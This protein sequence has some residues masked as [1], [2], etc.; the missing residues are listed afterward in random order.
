MDVAA[1]SRRHKLCYVNVTNYRT[2]NKLVYF[3]YAAVTYEVTNFFAA[4]D[5]KSSDNKI[6]QLLKTIALTCLKIQLMI[7]WLHPS[8]KQTDIF[9]LD[10]NRNK[11]S[12][13]VSR[14]VA[15]LFVF[16]LNHILFIFSFNQETTGN[17]VTDKQYVIEI[18]GV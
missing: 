2:G 1:D 17:D 3:V 18:K 4:K 8:P 7:Y 14:G 6:Y 9:T 15:L 12:S 16:F 13:N 11:I 5:A 10:T